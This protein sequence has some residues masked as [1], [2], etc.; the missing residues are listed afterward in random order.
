M[1]KLSL[2]SLAAV[3]IACCFV[4]VLIAPVS[5]GTDD[6]KTYDFEVGQGQT[7]TLDLRSG[8]SVDIVGWE[9]PRAEVSYVQGGK[10]NRH[11]VEVVKDGNDLVVT[12]ETVPNE[13]QS[14]SLEFTIHVPNRFSV[15]LES[16]GGSLAIQGLDG[17]FK[18]TTMGGSLTLTDV[19]G[20]VKLETMGGNIQ[21]T[22][23]TLDGNLSTMGGTVY[24]KDVVGDIDAE[25]MGGNVKYE[26]VRGRDG[27][28]R[29]PGNISGIETVEDAGESINEKTV[30]ISTM[31]GNIV[32]D[33]APAGALVSTMG[34]DI[35]IE[36]ASKVID[37]STMGGNITLDV[38]DGSVNAATM[39]G[40]I[41]VV[42][43]KGLGE[44]TEGAN[45]SSCCGDVDLTVPADLSLDLDL[46]IKYT[47]NSSQ[48]FEI[49]SDFPVQIERSQEWDYSN[50]TP[51]K[52]IH[53]T[54]TVTGGKYPVVIETIN[55]D[56]RVLKA[57]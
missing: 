43:E 32:L 56:I 33:E 20:K 36:Q 42:I 57:K 28:L 17:D 48:D 16:S 5:S 34:G 15:T 10:G 8:G 18:G 25:S 39:A 19:K 55:G 22:D 27:K 45:L 38:I 29:V 50:G 1:H 37:A 49:R 31:G 6:Q 41:D 35:V 40:K 9:Q 13:G 7:I 24:L 52:S 47:K 12:S 14:R 26:N 23:A 11:D 4:A 3:C 51:R 30:T 44:G 46:T 54:S 2:C 53:A 21:V